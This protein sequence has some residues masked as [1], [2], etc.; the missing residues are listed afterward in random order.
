MSG[1]W[2]DDDTQVV[3]D[4]PKP[5]VVA[6]ESKPVP[7]RKDLRDKP[8][9]DDKPAKPIGVSRRG[10]LSSLGAHREASKV[11]NKGDDKSKPKADE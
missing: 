8:K 4:T 10:F 2:D 6:P 7:S 11:E 9:S 3:E 1:N 5:P